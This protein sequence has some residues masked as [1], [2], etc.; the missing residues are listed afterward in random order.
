[1][2]P[3][4]AKLTPNLW[5]FVIM[6]MGECSAFYP[7]QT[8]KQKKPH[9]HKARQRWAAIEQ[10]NQQSKSSTRTRTEAQTFFH[11]FLC[12]KLYKHEREKRKVTNCNS[13]V[14]VEVSWEIFLFLSPNRWL[15]GWHS[16][17]KK[18]SKVWSRSATRGT[19]GRWWRCGSRE[20]CSR[21]F[22]CCCVTDS[23]AAMQKKKCLILTHTHHC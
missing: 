16:L 5:R 8:R 14:M 19:E 1:M 21:S 4:G 9:K 23:S 12:P 17:R 20:L 3:T 11:V 13:V 10:Q 7:K 22:A 18:P 15:R 2:A 6:A